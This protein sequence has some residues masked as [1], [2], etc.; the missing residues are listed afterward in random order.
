MTLFKIK[1]DSEAL[2]LEDVKGNSAAKEKNIEE[3]IF[4]S[5][6]QNKNS[7]N[8]IASKIF[9]EARILPINRQQKHR[10]TILSF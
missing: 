4:E 2:V 10:T 5:L 1:K 9:G 7:E 3:I 8:T 6:V